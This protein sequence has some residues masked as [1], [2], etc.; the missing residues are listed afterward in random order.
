VS[1]ISADVWNQVEPARP[2]GDELVC[3]QA[4]PELTPR[5]LAAV[6]SRGRRHYLV[7]LEQT[8]DALRDSGSRGLTVLTEELVLPGQT[9]SRYIN[10]ICEDSL[11]HAMFDLLGSDIAERLNAGVD[12]AAEV[13]VRV[14]A[15]WRRF[16]G[17][18]PRQMLTR[19]AQVGLFAEIW[20][21][22]YWL[23][24]ATTPDQAVRMWRGPHGARHDFER[25][26]L[27][28]EAKGT[29]ST[30]GRIYK[31][32]GIR[33]LE[34]PEAGTLLFF[35]VRLREEAGASNT[36]P[37]LIEACRQRVR[38]DPNAE[39]LFETAI[40]AA[41]YSANHE[42]EYSKV[43]WRVVEGLLFDT[44]RTFPRLSTTSFSQEA[45]QGVEEIDYVI[46]LGT[47]EDAVVA[48]SPADAA[49]ILHAR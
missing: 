30:R 8:D 16:W 11:G 35:G 9:Q 22:N 1:G 27:S 44:A 14:L 40:I 23:L 2:G 5:L 25:A 33:Q 48:R 7:V 34:P 37:A 18:L 47:F 10:I 12:S 6:D 19:E 43:H 39:G 20:F 3:R 26:G 29:T 36:L 15:K 32:N 41:G 24:P 31:I 28:I 21:L 42:D 38:V 13:V 49:E 46:N 17:Q 45:L 4:A